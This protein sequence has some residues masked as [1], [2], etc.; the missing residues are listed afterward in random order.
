[1]F[2]ESTT[3]KGYDAKYL[4][5]CELGVASQVDIRTWNYKDPSQDEI[6]SGTVNPESVSGCVALPLIGSSA[7]KG[8]TK[9]LYGR[10]YDHLLEYMT[11]RG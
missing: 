2:D 3:Y 6:A 10:A 4:D 1:M 8:A 7:P 5:E 11:V 9:S